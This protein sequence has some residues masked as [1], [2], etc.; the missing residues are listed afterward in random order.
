MEY[1][2]GGQDIDLRYGYAD[3]KFSDAFV[4]RTGKFLIPAGRFN[5]YLYP[6]YL[7]KTVNRAYVNREISP[8][9]WAEVGLQLR[10]RLKPVGSAVPFYSAYLVNGL[11]GDSGDGIRNLRGNARDSKGG[12]D[13]KAIGGA[14]GAE[15]DNDIKVSA[16][17]YNG[18]YTPD[19]ELG[20]T[21]YGVSLYVDKEKFSFW[22]E[23]HGAV[24]ESYNDATDTSLG[25]TDLEKSG[26]YVQGGYMITKKI[27]AIGRYDQIEL[28]G[29][30]D[31]D[32]SRITVGLNYLLAKNAIFKVNYE[33]VSDDRADPDDNLLGFQLSIGF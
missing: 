7:N 19:N 27:E 4:V 30:P 25:T 23:Y 14:I 22:S 32:R 1:E 10:G 13:N 11:N 21:I 5:E 16:N 20:L 2:H 15:I 17:I 8:S 28:D 12:N 29:A 24:Q 18:K 9:A 26:F 6:E 33:I 31:D 3:Y